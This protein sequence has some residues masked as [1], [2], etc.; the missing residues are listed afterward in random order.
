MNQQFVDL[1]SDTVTRPTPEMYEA[2]CHAPLGD[3]VLN[4]DPTVARLEELAADRVGMESALFVPSGTMSNQIA[5]A[6]HTQPGD[7]V[8]FEDEAHL[9]YY[10]AG[11]PAVISGVVTRTVPSKKGVMAPEDVESRVIKRTHHSPGTSLI[12]V[13]NTHNRSGG[14]FVPLGH[15]RRYREIGDRFGIPL[16]LDGARVFNASVALCIDVSEIT[17]HFQSVSICLSKGLGS[18]VGSVL[19]GEH[20]FIE[21]ARFWRKR[22]GGGMRQAGILAA[23]GIVSLTRMVNRLAE[24]HSRAQRLAAQ[25][26][27]IEGTSIDMDGVVTNFVMVDT[28]ISANAWCERLY[29]HE[30][31]AMPFGSNRIRLVM[32]YDV[33]ESGVERA[34]EAFKAVSL[35]LHG[36]SLQSEARNLV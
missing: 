26:E 6:V 19:C 5:I 24:D 17:Q 25:L 27:G 28:V 33:D 11:A 12:C 3:D 1:R 29:E 31:L 30:V 16:H 35:E 18:P 22:L 34:A 7:S 36:N 23:C 2:M 9:L 20:D 32:H 14:N 8:L 21:Q 10:E 13:E 4:D 15:L